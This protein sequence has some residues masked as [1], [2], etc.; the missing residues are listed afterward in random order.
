M[1]ISFRHK[2]FLS[3]VMILIITASIISGIWYTHSRDLVTDTMLQ[4]TEILLD[5]R[6][7]DMNALI[8]NLD[9]QSRLLSYNNAAVD[10]GLG[11]QWKNEYLNSQ[12]SKKL[13]QYIDNVYAN[14]PSIQT[15]EIGNSKG[16]YYGRGAR[17]GYSFI[18]SEGIDVLLDKYPNELLILPY[19]DHDFEVKEIMFVRNISYYGRNIGYSLISI[20]YS[21]FDDIFSGVFPVNTVLTIQ[22]T[23][24]QLLYTTQNY[25]K[26]SDKQLTEPLNTA[27]EPDK[28]LITDM[29]NDQ[30]L[31][32]GKRIQPANLFIHV[33]V[34]MADILSDIKSK[35]KDIIYIIVI[36]VVV[37]LA[38][39]FVASR[40]ITRN[41]SVL[42]RA[43]RRFSDGDMDFK[44]NIR[45]NDEFSTL[46]TSYNQMTTSIKQYMQ[47]I[48][49]NEKE[50][51]ELEIRALQ[52][53]INLH[54]LFNALN[55]IKNLSY[56]Q[57]A[58][59]IE[60]L[61]SALMELL[62]ISMVN[63]NNFITLETEITYVQHFLEIFK[64]KSMKPIECVIDIEEEIREALVL[65]FMLQPIVENAIIHGIEANEEDRDG[66][67]YIKA[68]R[69][70]SD[71][72]IIVVDN[73]KGFDA[74]KV[75]QFNGIGIMNTDRRIKVHFG[76]EYGIQID[77]VP[78]VSTTVHIKIPYR[79]E[80]P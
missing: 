78:D 18:Q 33:A 71:I 75:S 7:G 68:I 64:Y 73:G 65:K 50:K 19:Y 58:T 35:F 54:F 57:R 9:Y 69:N 49:D 14:T 44:L 55:T 24:N 20:S 40:W 48:K 3:L 12:A 77:S 80:M 63:G 60:R 74:E 32:I 37:L 38:I 21:E 47:D 4:S 11:N 27:L 26:L 76:E 41:V 72:E 25:K 10:R 23:H 67:I 36:M 79:K 66:L 59:N 61:T 8:T 28:K 31:I 1:H 29:N 6:S 53:Q 52:G 45:S 2:L 15:L 70:D 42:S 16:Q 22:N 5:E 34:P 51:M 17:R 39:V 46:A 43:I 62:N 13:N 30:W 56:M